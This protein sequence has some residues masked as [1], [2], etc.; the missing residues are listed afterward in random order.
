MLL[1]DLGQRPVPMLEDLE[2][3]LE[4]SPDALSLV[5]AQEG[6]EEALVL[7][8]ELGATMAIGGR[9]LPPEV[10]QLLDRWVRLARKRLETEGWIDEMAGRAEPWDG[11]LGPV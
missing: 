4:R 10:M 11:L 2:R 8:R 1:V 5:I 7:A 6:D 9:V 3:V